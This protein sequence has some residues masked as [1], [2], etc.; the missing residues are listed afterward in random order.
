MK[1]ILIPMDFSEVSANAFMYAYKL[2]PEANLHVV[3]ASA[4]VIVTDESFY[5]TSSLNTVPEIKEEL[6][7]ILML[8]L[9]QKELPE[10]VDIHILRTEIIPAIKAYSKDNE[11]DAMVIGSRDKY[12]VFDKWVGTISL[13]LVKT[14]NLPTYLVPRYSGFKKLNKV[15]VA[16]DHHLKDENFVKRIREWNSD[17]NAFIKF[18]HVQSDISST[19]FQEEKDAIVHQMFEVDEVPFGFEIAVIKSGEV[20]QSLLESAYN[21]E[22]DLMIVMAENQTFI[23]S[24]LFKSMSKELILRSDIPILFLHPKDK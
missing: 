8:E 2:F 13:G 22:A 17:Y 6:E 11:L 14:I 9:A 1:N 16:S 12:D 3:H 21:F 15:I 19:G 18:L 24:L 5:Y 20:T 4:P 23:S 7:K 10:R